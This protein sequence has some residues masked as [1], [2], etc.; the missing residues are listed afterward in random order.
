VKNK[1]RTLVEKHKGDARSNKI[2]ADKQKSPVLYR[3]WKSVP[4]IFS[5]TLI[6]KYA[7]GYSCDTFVL[8]L[9]L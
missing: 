5:S 1:E 9:I 8:V 4:I 7:A 2:K 3:L 6:R